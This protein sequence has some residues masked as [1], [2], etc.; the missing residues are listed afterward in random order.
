MNDGEIRPR[1]GL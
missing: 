1:G